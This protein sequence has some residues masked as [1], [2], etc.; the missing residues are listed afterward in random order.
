MMYPRETM[1]KMAGL[2]SKGYPYNG[3]KPIILLHR[4]A[5]PPV[6]MRTGDVYGISSQQH[7]DVGKRRIPCTYI[8][9]ER[10]LDFDTAFFKGKK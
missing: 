7:S 10:R 4:S 6:P 5:V 2:Q 3:I 9:C 8:V 1:T